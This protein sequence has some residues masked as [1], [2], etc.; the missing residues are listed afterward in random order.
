MATGTGRFVVVWDFLPA[1]AGAAAVS[2]GLSARL[3]ASV[4]ARSGGVD[5][6][7]EHFCRAG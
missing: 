4:V 1:M 2:M 6:A 7:A 3:F 5:A